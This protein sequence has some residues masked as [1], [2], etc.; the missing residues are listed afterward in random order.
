MVRQGYEVLVDLV[1]QVEHGGTDGQAPL[2]PRGRE[3]PDVRLTAL[4]TGDMQGAQALAV[5]QG[6]A[7]S[8]EPDRQQANGDG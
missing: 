8:V 5:H 2:L 1:G 7:S 6:V 4:L 3:H